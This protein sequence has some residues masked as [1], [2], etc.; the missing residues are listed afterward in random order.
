MTQTRLPVHLALLL[1]VLVFAAMASAADMSKTLRVAFPVDITGFDPQVTQDLYSSYVQ[2]P[3]FEALLTYDYLARPYKLI[4]NTAEALP[5]VTDGGRTITIRVKRGI[6]FTP[7]PAFKGQKR[8]LTAA[9]YVYSWKR[10]LDP[11]VRSPNLFILENKLD[12]GDEAIAEAKKSGKFDYDKPL[13]GLKVLDRYTLQLKL[14]SPDYGLVDYMTVQQMSAVAREIVEAY[15]T[16]GSGWIQDRPVGT[17]P[18]RL[19]DWRRGSRLVFEAN[20]DFRD[21][22]FPE[23][24]DGPDSPPPRFSPSPR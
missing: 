21:K 15:G 12:G 7:D 9:D 24:G 8:E 6:T 1:P 20:P 5:E 2:R 19:K 4:P 3:I 13:E 17:G 18:Y 14:K 10:L 16:P 22:R 23:R 11:A